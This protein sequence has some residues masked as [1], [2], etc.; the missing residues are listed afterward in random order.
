MFLVF[1]DF[2]KAVLNDSGLQVMDAVA[3]QL[4]ARKDVHAVTIT[5][6]TDTSG[7]TK[8]NQRLSQ[9]RADAV[10]K[11]PDQSRRASPSVEN[12]GDG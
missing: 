9:R 2:N 6:F 3:K 1:Y 7:G 4:K 12:Q 8:Y 5:G 11:G 10:K